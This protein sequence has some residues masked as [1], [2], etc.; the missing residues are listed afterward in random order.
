MP[1][2]PNADIEITAFD[3]VPGFAR[4][5]VRDLRPR[6]ACEEL[7][8]PYRERLISALHRPDWYYREQPW[9]QVPHVRDGDVLIFESGATL[10]HL[11]ERDGGCADLLSSSGQE[12]ATV[13]SWTLAAFNSIEPFVFELS[14]VD[15]FSCKQEWAALRR[16]SLMND[17]GKR[18]DRLQESLGKAEWL[19]GTFSIADIAMITVLREV[20]RSGLLDSRPALAAYLE[21]GIAR[22]AFQTALAAQLAAFRAD[23]STSL[24]GA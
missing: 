16:P 8:L 12:R 13:L 22:P 14:N 2:D 11:A 17:L 10:I 7:G 3:W 24:Q 5:Y 4:G 19:A 15:I 18:L 6:W 23:A 9:G 1:I 20:G 21:R